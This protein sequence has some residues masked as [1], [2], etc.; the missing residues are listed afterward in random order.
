MSTFYSSSYSVHYNSCAA[1]PLS[2]PSCHALPLAFHASSEVNNSRTCSPNGLSDADSASRSLPSLLDGTPHA[3]A[4]DE[5][6]DPHS[7]RRPHPAG[8]QL[9]LSPSCE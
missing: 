5:L 8:M 4:A 2:I 7:F 3:Y 9:T 6:I 1:V